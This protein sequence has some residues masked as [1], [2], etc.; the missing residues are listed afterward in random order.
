MAVT[1]P[2]RGGRLTRRQVLRGA[3]GA[4][5]LAVA[6]GGL[7]EALG[8]S[9]HRSKPLPQIGSFAYDADGTVHVFHSQP[10]LHPPTVKI[11]PVVRG[12]RLGAGDP[13]FLFLGPGPVSLSGSDQYG[14]LI[15]DHNG[16]PV[17][18]RP[19]AKGLQATNFTAAEYRGEPVLVWWE[20]K[21]LPS[22]YGQGEAVIVN[23][24]Y[25]EIARV[26]AAGGRS[27]DLHAL[28]LTPQG[29][30]LF[31]CY[32]ESVPMDLSSIN[33]PK[34]DQVLGSIIQEVDVATG[35]LL[36]EWH[37]LQH[38]PVNV[39]EEPMSAPYD[40]LHVN[41]I[42]QLSDG[43]LLVSARHTWAIYKLDRSSG[44]LIWTLG[45]KHS[46]F[47]MGK[48]AQFFWQHDATQV[49]DTVLTVFDNGTNGPIDSEKQGRGL[50]LD[51]DETR[52][53]VTLRH[54]Y[55]TPQHLLAGA[56]GSV[57]ILPSGRVMVGWGVESHT[58]EFTADGDLLVDAALP[59]GT[60]SYRGLWLPWGATPHHKPA[61]AAKP[62]RTSGATI[63]Y[64]SWN[65]ATSFTGWQVE[66]GARHDQLR[67]LGI[68]RRH[69][70][71]TGIPLHSKHRFVAVTAINRSGKRLKRSPVIRI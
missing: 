35:R 49:N 53:T 20:G 14:P 59:D 8:G 31:T 65:G 60:Y 24:A 18:F 43:N 15:V 32:P 69:G 55:T 13:G 7:A 64:A 46:D 45:G 44:K 34:N 16:T 3:G 39:S 41:S 22:G 4:A 42:Q 63:V 10:G 51:V 19:L 26:R 9:H 30:A 17:W 54:A 28:T 2:A 33:G 71:E 36:F 67:P 21:I 70:F 48:D 68:A 58:S 6:G 61:V 12:E 40:Y 52:R 50:V 1:D 23:R 37:G 25:Q 11:T 56:M 47:K 29:T 57:Q 38:V 62:D 66:A 5:L 27:M